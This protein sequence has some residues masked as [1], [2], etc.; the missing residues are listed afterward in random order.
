[1][2]FNTTGKRILETAMSFCG[3]C[4]NNW[5]FFFAHSVSQRVFHCALLFTDWHSVQCKKIKI[6]AGNRLGS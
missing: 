1:M 6:K 4:Q 2:W 5:P 3:R